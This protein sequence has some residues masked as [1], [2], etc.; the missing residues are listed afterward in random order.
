MENQDH[1]KFDAFIKKVTK[2]NPPIPN[3]LDLSWED[4]HISF[5]HQD[6][7]GRQK[8][9]QIINTIITEKIEVPEDL[10]LAW[11][12]MDITIPSSRK[13]RR[14]IYLFF[15]LTFLL[16]STSAAYFL[17]QEIPSKFESKPE[18][19]TQIKVQG[20]EQENLNQ[21]KNSTL[22]DESNISTITT[23][24]KEASIKTISNIKKDTR[25]K[26]FSKIMLTERNNNDNQRIIDETLLSSI[27]KK[28]VK[29]KVP[30]HSNQM[31]AVNKKVLNQSNANK[32]FPHKIPPID[33]LYAVGIKAPIESIYSQFDNPN[34]EAG[35]KTFYVKIGRYKGDLNFD[36]NPN[37]ENNIQTNFGISAAIGIQK[38]WKHSFAWSAGVNYNEYHTALSH[39][40][41]VSR[42]KIPGRNY[43]EVI[44]E[45]VYKNNYSRYLGFDIGILKQFQLNHHIDL[46]TKLSISQSMLISKSGLALIDNQLVDMKDVENM[47]PFLTSIAP[48]LGVNYKLSQKISLN[49]FYEFNYHLTEG[50][51][52]NT[53]VGSKHAHQ[54]GLALKFKM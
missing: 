13:N 12:E 50:P 31:D 44:C 49:A 26:L 22:V 16:A 3:D 8:I 43:Y 5:E 36:Q 20:K 6:A 52:I 23:K 21:I 28:V 48:S 46:E 19:R 37:V 42:T 34:I 47:N 53:Q 30:F 14:F 54:A 24:Q 25:S 10:G 4:M 9:D 15:L 11:E 39:S 18:V 35:K 38:R 33:L 32:R 40:R 7:E 27:P 41:E 51:Y 17:L 2:E 1:K 45:H 29:H